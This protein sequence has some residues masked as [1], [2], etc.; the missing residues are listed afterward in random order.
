LDSTKQQSL[1]F[2]TFAVSRLPVGCGGA[3][4]AALLAAAMSSIDSGIN[5]IATVITAE[6]RSASPSRSHVGKAKW[7]TLVAGLLIT[8]AAY[9]LSFLPDKWG[10]VDAMPRT[11]NAITAPLGGLFLVGMFL[12]RVAERAVLTGVIAGLATSVGL[13]YF[14]QLAPLLSVFGWNL[15]DR[16]LSFTWIM[17][18]SLTVTFVVSWLVSLV[19]GPG[20][21][22]RDGLTWQT[23]N[24]KPNKDDA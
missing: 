24:A 6:Q 8:L 19:E 3:I 7:I 14:E 9:C 5:S 20:Q 17:P 11:F 15:A 2:P 4:L 10:V 18:C 13:G 12:P 1:I 21:R 16:T 22:D 23:R